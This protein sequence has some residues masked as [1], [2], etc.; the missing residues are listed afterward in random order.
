M[1]LINN[2]DNQLSTEQKVTLDY[3][4]SESSSL[5]SVESA[6]SRG[7]TNS[8]FLQNGVSYGNDQP[9]SVPLQSLKQEAKN[10]LS[11]LLKFL[12]DL[13]DLLR[14]VKLELEN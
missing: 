3:S 1:S 11:D 14:Q 13:E 5:S 12:K 2:I 7:G 4:S 6:F 10:S 8:V 9:Y